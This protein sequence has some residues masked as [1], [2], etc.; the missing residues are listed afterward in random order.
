MLRAT[1]S[2]STKKLQNVIDD[3][4]S[5]V[6]KI[7]KLTPIV[8]GRIARGEREDSERERKE[9]KIDREENRIER[10]ENAEFR[11]TSQQGWIL[12]I[13][14]HVVTNNVTNR[15]ALQRDLC[16]VATKRKRR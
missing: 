3:L 14:S 5:E 4:T 13:T 12:S 16:V 6:E 8:E 9:A 2:F 15:K 1:T 11:H 7:D 10:K